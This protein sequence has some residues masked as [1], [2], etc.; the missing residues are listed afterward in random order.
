[1]HRR[2]VASV[3]LTCCVALIGAC[4]STPAP[5][6][7]TATPASVVNPAVQTLTPG[8]S[9]AAAPTVA[10]T[11]SVA[12]TSLAPPPAI[13]TGV[14]SSTYAWEYCAAIGSIDT[15]DARLTGDGVRTVIQDA[16]AVAEKLPNRF[17]DPA[18]RRTPIP[19]RCMDG[20]VWA[21]D[22]GANLP[23]G[24]AKTTRDPSVAMND[25]CAQHPDGVLP[26]F[27]TGHDTIYAWACKGG[28]A[29]IERQ[30]FTVDARGF[31][32]N[33]WYRLARP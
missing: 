8:A 11:P 14:A 6:A 26:A 21:C 16:L 20:G 5:S 2:H 19:W 7:A 27:V 9:A 12:S 28:S 17:A 24:P 3:L 1:M 33:F 30:A 13:P 15:P 31:V 25:Y 10:A 4:T 23:C 22:P 32:A 18:S 29:V